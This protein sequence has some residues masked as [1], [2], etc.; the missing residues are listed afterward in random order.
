MTPVDV[1][2]GVSGL[3]GRALA[4][5]LR[6]QGS[7]VCGVDVAPSTDADIDEYVQA[8][9][10]DPSAA[11]AALSPTSRPGPVWVW[12]LAAHHGG[13]AYAAGNAAAILADNLRIDANVCEA[14]RTNGAAR[15]LYASS[16][17]VYPV[18]PH[19]GRWVESNAYPASPCDDYGWSK[20][21]GERLAASVAGSTVVRLENCY[22]PPAPDGD[23]DGVLPGLCRR[24]HQVPPGGVLDVWGDPTVERAFLWVDDA[25]AALIAVMAAGTSATYNVTS[26][27]YVTIGHVAELVAEISGKGLVVRAGVT[28]GGR[29]RPRL[30]DCAIRGL[31]WAPAVPLREGVARLYEATAGPAHAAQAVE[32]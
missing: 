2:T 9:L 11:V 23:R 27:E 31:G 16:V 8:D 22:G 7:W 32:P 21:T 20:L 25:V 24:A 10:R 14:A 1:V 30:D 18:V 4:A 13:V 6:G 5:E 19:T 29:H 12:H 17:A 28:P 26:S 3:I 15:L